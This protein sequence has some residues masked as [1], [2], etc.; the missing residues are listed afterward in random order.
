MR[1]RN[2]QI[3]HH[4]ALF[5]CVCLS[6]DFTRALRLIEKGKNNNVNNV[7]TLIFIY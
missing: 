5:E 3:V 4:S 7:A 6:Y 1:T 2:R